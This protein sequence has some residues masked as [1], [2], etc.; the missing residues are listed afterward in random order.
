MSGDKFKFKSWINRALPPLTDRRARNPAFYLPGPIHR[1]GLVSIKRVHWLTRT[2]TT[3]ELH[4]AIYHWSVPE[5]GVGT[6]SCHSSTSVKHH[7]NEIH[8]LLCAPLLCWSTDRTLANYELTEI[9]KSSGTNSNLQKEMS[10]IVL[11]LRSLWRGTGFVL[12]WN[13]NTPQ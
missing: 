3:P 2:R 10:N 5:S 12:G 11:L 1:G 4:L 9:D 13:R 6:R 7:P 8:T